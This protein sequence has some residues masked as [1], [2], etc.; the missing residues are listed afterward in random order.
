MQ[1][2]IEIKNLSFR[3]ANREQVIFQNLNLQ[4]PR[5]KLT[6]IMGSSGCGKSTMALSIVGIIPNSIEGEL[7]GDI[8]L[9]GQSI[10]GEL[11]GKLS[12]RI[13]IVFQDPESQ[14]CTFTVEDEIAFGLENLNYDTEEIDRKIDEALRFVN[15]ESYRYHQLSNLSGGE[16]QKI[17][18]CSILTMG[19][20]CIILDEPTANL[21]PKSSTEIFSLLTQLRDVY[22]KTI[23]IIEHKLD[24]LI[25]KVDN[26]V[27]FS[28]VGGIEY[29]GA[30]TKL[31]SNI[32][33]Y[34]NV[35]LPHL[36]EIGVL[37]S[38]LREKNRNLNFFIT[39]EAALDELKKHNHQ[40]VKGEL[41]ERA[42]GVL[43][44]KMID[45][46]NLSYSYNSKDKVLNN[47][48]LEVFSGEFLAIA[49]AN[50]AGKSTLSKIL[51]GLYK[52]FDGDV[53]IQDKAI[54][55]YR[56]KELAKKIGLVFQNPEHQFI[57]NRVYDE[58]SYSLILNKLD[59]SLIDQRVNEYLEWFNLKDYEDCN[60]FQLSQGQKRRLSVASML[61]GGQEILILD[62][63]TYGQDRENTET[64]MEY[65]KK[66]N[67]SGVT[68][69]IITHDMNL[70]SNYCSRVVLL[71]NGEK[72]YDGGPWELFENSEL[73]V[74]GSIEVP[75][76][77]RLSLALKEYS[78]AF[79]KLMRVGDYIECMNGGTAT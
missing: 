59:R 38:K 57:S 20:A 79:P 3:Y 46:K 31:I 25:S 44:E 2:A 49:G 22:G 74:K 62:E 21:D 13:G 51:L 78:P 76:I 19:A 26:I 48:K 58:L 55:A 1:S 39:H 6:L 11:P 23:I 72:M 61:I 9:E 7:N 77:T 67:D 53:F 70:I 66:L 63:P 42:I 36:P 60:P 8:L 17:A 12:T 29:T 10:K 18:I 56:K 64:L 14:F 40:F 68:I 28:K 27:L 52:N 75:A 73:V 45:I 50:G 47:L 33:E 34:E 4:I 54:N 5:G 37:S 65:M 41:E 71:S 69:I 43:G 35:I 32:L 16:K 15:M 24:D 30:P